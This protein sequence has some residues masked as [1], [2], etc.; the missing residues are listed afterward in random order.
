[1]LKTFFFK[2]VATDGYPVGDEADNDVIISVLYPENGLRPYTTTAH[3][4][5]VNRVW[6]T[7]SGDFIPDHC[8][9]AWAKMP[10]PVRGLALDIEPET[11]QMIFSKLNHRDR[12]DAAKKMAAVVWCC[13]NCNEV[14]DDGKIPNR[15]FMGSLHCGNCDAELTRRTNGGQS[16][17]FNLTFKRVE[18]VQP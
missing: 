9:N 15:N 17:P 13:E 12:W 6:C 2:F 3:F 1:M 11:P 14:V 16:D 5:V 18:D 7:P 8:V 4:A 10:D